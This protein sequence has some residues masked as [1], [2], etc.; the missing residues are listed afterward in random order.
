MAYKI[1]YT[2][3][4]EFPGEPQV[5]QNVTVPSVNEMNNLIF[6]LSFK[7]YEKGDQTHIRAR[8]FVVTV[9]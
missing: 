6:F 4:A 1:E 9:V 2:V 5:R 7:E 8:D 3:D